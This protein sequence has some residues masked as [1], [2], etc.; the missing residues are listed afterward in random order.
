MFT[1][2][3]DVCVGVYTVSSSNVT[4]PCPSSGLPGEH[5]IALSR[6]RA[7]ILGCMSGVVH[8][9]SKHT[10]WTCFATVESD[11]LKKR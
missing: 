7:S 6:S 2:T 10:V 1:A 8:T 3:T 4:M 5:L 11:R 9:S